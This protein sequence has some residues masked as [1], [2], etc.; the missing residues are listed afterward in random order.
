[1]FGLFVL[2]ELLNPGLLLLLLS[3][4]GSVMFS[5]FGIKLFLLMDKELSLFAD[6][7]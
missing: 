7:E 1:M 3:L 2:F 6:E 4:A 5:L